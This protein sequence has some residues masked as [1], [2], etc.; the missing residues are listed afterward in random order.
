MSRLFQHPEADDELQAALQ[1][2]TQQGGRKA[3]RFDQKVDG[4]MQEIRSRPDRFPQLDAE[5]REAPVPKFPY[6]VIYRALPSGDVQVI[7]VAHAS[8]EPGYWRDRA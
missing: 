2:Y 8:R 5:F 6:S 1:W 4:V 7:A 3:L